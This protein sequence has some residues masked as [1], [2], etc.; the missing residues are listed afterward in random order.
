MKKITF[1]GVSPIWLKL[2]RSQIRPLILLILLFTLFIYL[3]ALSSRSGFA[4]IDDR[5]PHHLTH[6][7]AQDPNSIKFPI[8]LEG[9]IIEPPENFTRK[10]RLRLEVQKII[11][12]RQ[13]VMTTVMTSENVQLTWYAPKIR[14]K[15]Y[16][17][18]QVTAKLQIPLDY[19]N[20]GGFSYSDYLSQKN[21]YATGTIKTLTLYNKA[22]TIPLPM[23]IL[24]WIYEF[25]S[26]VSEYI[27]NTTSAPAS[28]LLQAILLGERHKVSNQMKEL[29]SEAGT[30]H[31]LSVC[32]FHLIILALTTFF[33]LRFFLQLLPA[34]LFESLSCLIRPS[35]LAALLSIP[36]VIFYTILTGSRT[37][38][39]RACIIVILYF[40]SLLFE[41]R[42]T[43]WRPLILAA[44]CILLWQPPAIFRVDFQLTFLASAGVIFMIEYLF[45]KSPLWG[46]GEQGN[47]EPGGQLTVLSSPLQRFLAFLR[48]Y[49]LLSCCLSLAAFL[50]ISPL[51][52]YF[53]NLVSPVGIFTNLLATP[54]VAGILYTGLGA[55]L[56]IPFCPGL[57]GILFRIGALF[58]RLIVSLNTYV[59]RVPRAFFYLA[60]PPK[61][62]VFIIYICIFISALL[63]R[64]RTKNSPPA[65]KI[66]FLIPTLFL[67]LVLLFFLLTP[68]PRP[69]PRDL[70]VTFLDVGKGDACVIQTP[71]GKNI[72]IDGGG[73]YNQ[74]E[75]DFGHSVIAPYLWHEKIDKL[76]LVVLTH[77]HPDHLNGLL[78]ILKNF[79]VARLWK[80]KKRA[81]FR[82]YRLFE[83]IIGEKRIPVRT[84][85]VGEQFDL[86]GHLLEVLADG[87]LSNLPIST[88]ISFRDENNRSLVLKL[89]YGQISFL[90][91]GD[92]ESKAERCLLTLGEKLRSTILKV[93][94]H[95]SRYSSSLPFLQMVRPQAVVFSA[96]NYG[97]QQFPHP[98]A[99]ARY[100]KLPCQIY[101]TDLDG[102]IT[103]ETD[104]AGFKVAPYA[105]VNKGSDS[106]PTA[107][108]SPVCVHAR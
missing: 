7:L 61:T 104:G 75:F 59:I 55:T 24:R 77:P 37:S 105:K 6:Y 53:F 68:S 60:S 18:V 38:T 44:F 11:L 91:A 48:R 40:L 8:T 67:L 41:R 107:R 71:K 62:S 50:M 46:T 57:A 101:R 15:F 34:R 36:V 28:N 99:L 10:T 17:T 21:I 78:F 79:P 25:R 39:I 103:F 35:R 13:N 12:P 43:L 85:A 73:S 31:L 51:A 95:G 80:T 23:L 29:F 83:K 81:N 30:I 42:K 96:R 33:C 32:G 87:N 2:L 92:I 100:Q 72:L 5:F 3:G 22:K 63:L 49:F 16:D 14:C 54:L 65:W 93:P 86:D 69:N 52:A 106:M 90:F 19:R 108:L 70:T 26:R 4:Q 98:M 64:Y 102:A 45:A 56:M 74:D 76:D 89:S 84:P 27:E 1:G 20:P 94:H 88:K 82:E 58:T 66:T 47:K 9:R 97:K